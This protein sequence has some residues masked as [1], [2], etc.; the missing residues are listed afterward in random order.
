MGKFLLEYPE[1]AGKIDTIVLDPPRA[2]I[3]PRPCQGHPAPSQ[4]HG[5]RLLQSR[6]TGPRHRGTG[7]VR[8]TKLT[9]VDQFPY[10]AH[11][12]AVGVFE[13]QQTLNHEQP[14]PQIRTD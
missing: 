9:L 11:V 1:Y 5:V 10:T 6:Y 3:R 14:H 4:A 2:G 7:E 13:K 12:E 8:L